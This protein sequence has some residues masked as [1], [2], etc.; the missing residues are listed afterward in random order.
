MATGSVEVTIELQA[1]PDV[2]THVARLTETVLA[3]DGVMTVRRS[4]A[5]FTGPPGDVTGDAMQQAMSGEHQAIVPDDVDPP[6]R[7]RRG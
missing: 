1:T 7:G 4:P 5:L 6:R 3:V 2:L